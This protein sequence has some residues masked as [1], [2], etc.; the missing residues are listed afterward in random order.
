MSKEIM[1]IEEIYNELIEDCQSIIIQT[2]KDAENLVIKGNYLLGEA[3]LQASQHMDVTKLVD[4][5][6][7][8]LRMSSRKLWYSVKF[9]KQFKSWDAV[10][11]IIEENTTWTGIKQQY[12]T[13][14]DTPQPK[15]IDQGHVLLVD[16][17]ALLAEKCK[18]FDYHDKH[19]K[20]PHP[21]DEL[22]RDLDKIQKSL[23]EG[24]YN[25]YD[26]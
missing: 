15:K 26:K 3:I 9:A 11:K 24:N 4:R 16:D 25:N 13:E 2:W 1:N 12:L 23:L 22:K 21:K 17:I 7:G 14:S 8:D 19:S 10:N 6:S 20:L 18:K 5:V